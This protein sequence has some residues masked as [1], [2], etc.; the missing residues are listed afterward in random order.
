MLW[1]KIKAARQSLKEMGVYGVLMIL[2]KGI[3]LM[4]L[5][6]TTRYLSLQDYGLLES[7]VV[8]FS[9]CSLLEISAGAL[10]R[11]YPD[12]KNA[13]AKANLISSSFVLSL[14]YGLL[15]AVLAGLS[16]HFLPF[17]LFASLTVW[18]L[19]AVAAVVALSIALQPLM[20]WLRIERRANR[21][22]YLVVLQSLT[23]VAV[24]LWGLQ[25][26]WGINAVISA[27][28][29]ANVVGLSLGVWFCREQI[30]LRFD[31]AL[32]KLTLSY[33][34]CLIGASLALFVMH[35]LD[36]LLLAEW[37]GAETL[38]Q[39]AIMIKVVEATAMAFGVI[40]SWWLPRRFAVLQHSNGQMEVTVIHQRLLLAIM[41]LLLS[42]A[43]FAPLLLKAVLPLEY[44]A[45][46]DWLPLML[47]AVGFKLATA[48]TDIGC[49]LP[50]SPVWLPRINAASAVLAISLYYLL[51]P[52]WG[53]WGLIAA[54]NSVF[55]LRFVMFTII[56]LILQPLQY[57]VFPLVVAFIPPLMLL[58]LLPLVVEV[59]W[60][61]LLP[62]V[63][64]IW[65]MLGSVWVVKPQ[66][67]LSSAF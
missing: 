10:P 53:V 12:C 29:A 17:E 41:L 61:Q 4:M 33:Q 2:Q 19:T 9:L 26:G 24:T 11:F 39:Y 16:L 30:K 36:R 60:A 35:G 57:R 40:E 23:Q 62:M 64:L 66:G 52:A 65:L 49:Y 25:H 44:L 55:A 45:G 1:N 58:L 43:C 46:I 67:Q 47:L 8:I 51:I 42:A 7:L 5:P 15:L 54:T 63:G 6:V 28:V 48:V 27:S 34:S 14:A 32:A 3:G 18:Q 56:S 13:A 20:M 50:N 21:Y 37:L 59:A 22:F 38:A 31:F